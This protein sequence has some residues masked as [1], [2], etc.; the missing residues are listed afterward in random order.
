M[1]KL[2]YAVNDVRAVERVLLAQG[3]RRDRILTLT[4]AQATKAAIE[5]V[6]ADQLR[7]KM[8]ASDRLLVFFAGHG[9]TD[10]LRSGEEEGY[11]LPA[12]ADPEH[13]FS[14]AISMAALR[15]IAERLP[16]RHMAIRESGRQAFAFVLIGQWQAEVGDRVSAALSFHRALQ[17]AGATP[18]DP[19]LRWW[20][21]VAQTKAGDQAAARAT[22]Q[23][24][25]QAAGPGSTWLLRLAVAEAEAGDQAT[26]GKTFQQ[27][28][29]A[30]ADDRAKADQLRVLS[31]DMQEA[32]SKAADLKLFVAWATGQSGSRLRS[33]ALAAA[34]D[35]M[36]KRMKAKT[37]QTAPK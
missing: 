34:A 29:D 33:Y 17:L 22:V 32:L 13:L 25:S 6:L 3:F 36:L 11:L 10:T 19:S 16:A 30:I 1:R 15:Q 7:A 20:I 26:A 37:S 21:A 5:R 18:E 2:R 28:L 9:K 23:Q 12:D 14:T 27:A 31:L 4:D 35:V 8:G 24:A